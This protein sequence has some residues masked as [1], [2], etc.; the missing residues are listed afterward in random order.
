MSF[1]IEVKTIL[2]YVVLIATIGMTW[3]MWSERLNAV[4]KKADSVA[5]MQQDIAIIKSKILDMD[6]RVAWIEE[7]LIKTSDF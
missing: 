2:P 1:K 3:G 5:E 4:E 7:F 6:D